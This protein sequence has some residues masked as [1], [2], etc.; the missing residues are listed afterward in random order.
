MPSRAINKIRSAPFGL[1]AFIK[2]IVAF[3]FSFCVFVPTY[4]NW[5]PK[6]A[7][8]F[9]EVWDV[10]VTHLS[11]SSSDV[12]FKF[13]DTALRELVSWKLGFL[14]LT[15]LLTETW[16]VGMTSTSNGASVDQTIG[17]KTKGLNGENARECGGRLSVRNVPA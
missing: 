4:F 1:I 6:A 10:T 9:M 3:S 15:G 2:F 11:L 12:D 8:A 13:E 7:L 5:I 14:L 16:L 17:R